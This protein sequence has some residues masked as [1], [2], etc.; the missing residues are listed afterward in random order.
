M[1]REGFFSPCLL[2]TDTEL[3]AKIKQQKFGLDDGKIFSIVVMVSPG[4][5]SPG[6]S[7]NLIYWS[8]V[9]RSYVNIPCE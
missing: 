5:G 3:W 8:I 2:G 7:W 1:K 4:A 9:G 6:K